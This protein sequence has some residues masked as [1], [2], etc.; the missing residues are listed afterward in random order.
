MAERTCGRAPPMAKPKPRP[1]RKVAKRV[2]RRPNPPRVPKFVGREASPV[3][4]HYPPKDPSTAP[5]GPPLSV[6]SAPPAPSPPRSDTSPPSPPPAGVPSQPLITLDRPFDPDEFS[7]LLGENSIR[8]TVPR[9]ALPEVLR[10]VTEFMGFGIYV[11]AL[12]VR[13]APTELLKSFVVELQRVD[14]SAEKQAWLP[15]VEKGTTDSPFGP[16]GDRT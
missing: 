4:D 8:V 7:S 2:A 12:S 9:D 14:F 10:R 15:F 16:S 3:L 13:P 1:S 6:T 5:R 11:Y